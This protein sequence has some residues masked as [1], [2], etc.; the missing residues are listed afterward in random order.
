MIAIALMLATFLFPAISSGQERKPVWELGAGIGLLHIPDYRGSNESRFYALPYP[1]IIYRGDIIKVDRQTVYG[2][3]FKTDRVLLDVSYYGSVPV[4]SDKNDARTGMP[5]LDPTFEVGPA[6]DIR[7]FEN[8]E[9]QM[10][11]KL[12]L[13][14]RPVFSTDFSSISC[15]GWLISPRL[16][17]QKSDIIPGSGVNLGISA[18][19]MFADSGYH[20]YYYTVGPANATP[21]RP[22]YKAGGG[23]SGSTVTVALSKRYKRLNITTFVSADLLDGAVFENSPLVKTKTSIM[24]GVSVSWIFY[25]SVRKITDDDFDGLVEG[26]NHP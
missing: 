3:I 11:L 17:F 1:Y 23:Y 2:K 16:N 25:K 10:A 20:D 4:D 8:R 24:S 6:L 7:I 21:T 15:E 13:P 14:V 9:N 22:A 26:Q 12:V 5:D 18:G 19:P